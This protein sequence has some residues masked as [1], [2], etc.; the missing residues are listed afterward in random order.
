MIRLIQ[1]KVRNIPIYIGLLVAQL[2]TLIPIASVF[3]KAFFKIEN[4]AVV[5]SLNEFENILLLSEK[6]HKAY[7]NSLIISL[8]ITVGQVIIGIVLAWI[9]T[10]YQFP[11]KKFLWTVI[12]F[13]MIL[14]P[15][16]TLVQNYSIMNQLELIDTYRGVIY[17]QLF[18]PIGVIFLRKY[19][20]RISQDVIDAGYLDGT[21][22]VTQLTS[23]ILPICKNGIYLLA[24]L[25]FIDSYNIYELPLVLLRDLSK[26]PLSLLVRNIIEN[27]PD[28]IFVPALIYMIPAVI[29]FLFARNTIMSGLI[30]DE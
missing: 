29:V 13:T 15:Q 12:L 23:I 7:A 4:E 8:L 11:L 20:S 5:F 25:S 3:I 30:Y 28:E 19:F 26:M 14:P 10:A 16:A 2:I 18:Y 24:F 21:N 9:F 6:F 27:Y 17:P 22:K 1:I